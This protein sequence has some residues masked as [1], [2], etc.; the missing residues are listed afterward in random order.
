M[1][2]I[3]PAKAYPK[4]NNE[5]ILEFQIPESKFQVLL[6]EVYLHFVVQIDQT[7]ISGGDLIPQNWFAAK[8][9]S[10]VEVKLNDESVSRRSMPQEYA[11]STYINS[12]V[13]YSHGLTK[14][15][16]RSIGVF[17]NTNLHTT[18]IEAMV[19]KGTWTRYCRD[20]K[21][22]NDTFAYEI[23]MP[24]DNTLFY[25]DN[26][27]PSGQKWSLSFERAETKFSTLVTA[28][29][30]DVSSV[31]KVL[32]L[33][34]VYL[35]IP[36]TADEKMKRRESNWIHKPI[37][38]NY[39]K[40]QLQRYTLES[41]SNYVRIPNIINGKLPK[42]LLFGIMTD[43]SYFGSF[44][45]SSTLFKRHELVEIDL[46]KNG[47]SMPG[48]P[49]KMSDAN[50]TIPYVR[51]L[52]LS[53]KFLEKNTTSVMNLQVFNDYN[54]L[55]CATF[56]EGS[57]GSLS[58]EFSFASNVPDGLILIVFSI[59]DAQMEIDKFGNFTTN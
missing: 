33:D 34:D 52:E 12:I 49:I 35:M 44:K 7:K 23:I 30:A 18:L 56:P 59:Y 58:V 51:F 31:P 57:I 4:L 41:G 19:K 22:V 38:I 8:Q 48:M 40:Y 50:V 15:G 10:S 9:F 43:E 55:H 54:F 1:S 26:L 13:N 11:L 42:V 3:Y 28:A 45:E 32:P 27:L 36:Y 16:C 21:S 24:I 37:P 46:L 6:S 39:D 47:S 17:D 5:D 25:S 29:D 20:R 53:G 2:N 14:S